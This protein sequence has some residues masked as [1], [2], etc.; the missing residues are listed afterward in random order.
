MAIVL[1][2]L[3][4][5][6]G[7]HGVLT[8][9]SAVVPEGKVTAIMAPSGQ[10]KTTLLRILM[11]LETPDSGKISGLSGKK[12]SA[13]FQENRL[14]DNLSPVSNIRLVA[15]EQKRSQIIAAMEGVLLADCFHQPV[16]ELSGGMRRR[17]AILRALLADYDI[18]FLD[19]PFKGLDDKTRQVV[20]RDAKLRSTGKTVFLITHDPWEAQIMEACQILTLR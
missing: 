9:F 15:P 6:Y 3:C 8:D 16:R 13:V 7:N 11:G 4:K 19:E 14:C 20:I 2:K 10:G 17:V 5:A 1:E 18:L 12:F